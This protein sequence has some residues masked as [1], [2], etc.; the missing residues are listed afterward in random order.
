MDHHHFGH[1]NR[2]LVDRM[3]AKRTADVYVFCWDCSKNVDTTIPSLR[4]K[5][6]WQG[7]PIEERSKMIQGKVA[8]HDE[9]V[10]KQMDKPMR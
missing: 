1:H 3:N 8:Y 7:K 9:N 10:H 6:K 4:C 2:Q 5:Q